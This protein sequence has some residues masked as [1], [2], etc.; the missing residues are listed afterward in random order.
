MREIKV[1]VNNLYSLS[2]IQFLFSCP[3]MQ[4]SAWGS[5]KRR[6]SQTLF[7][8]SLS[9]FTSRTSYCSFEVAEEDHSP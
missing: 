8:S 1:F 4:L 3:S 7:S 6:E 2:R 5:V 9:R